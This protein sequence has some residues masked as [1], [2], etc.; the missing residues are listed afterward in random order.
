[1]I[2]GR[3]YEQTVLDDCLKSSKSE[4]IVVYGRRRVGKTHLIKEFFE[5]RFS[6]YATGISEVNLSEELDYFND[7][8]IEYGC[9]D[10]KKTNNWREAFIKLKKLLMSNSV[11][12]DPVSNK[13]IVFLDELPWMDTPKS[14]FK[15]ALD[16]FWNSWASTEKDIVMI[17][18]GSATSW[19]INNILSG[20]GG[21]YNRITRQIHLKPFTLGECEKFFEMN[22]IH[23]TRTDIINSY[24]VFG[25]IP[26]YLGLFSRRLSLAQNIDELIFSEVGQLH[27]EYDRLFKSLFRNSSK[28]YLIMKA[29]TTNRGGLSRKDVISKTKIADGELLTR[30]LEELEQC[31][32]IRKYK[33]Y[34]KETKGS[35]YQIIDPFTLFCN[36]FNDK[37]VSSW[38]KYIRTPDYNNWSG[39]AFELVSLNHVQQIKETLGISGIETTEYS[40]KSKNSTPG[41]QID[42]LIDRADNVINI[43]EIKHTESEYSIDLKYSESLKNKIDVFQKE[44]NCKKALHLVMVCS[45]HLK[46]NKYSSVVVNDI[47]GDDL[48]K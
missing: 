42:L 34:T 16:H 26:Y 14:N 11:T 5:N 20:K 3:K 46:Y 47:C 19:I 17:V 22:D 6:F 36:T 33:N 23:M 4:F 40:W 41:A 38:M 43:C 9:T 10:H 30:A 2:I 18:C 32:F 35:Y 44:T 8:L 45:N 1:M 48:F 13:R 27:Y 21:F 25:G 39:Y 15:S 31:G 28:H 12:R 29:L 7:S 24:M 37:N